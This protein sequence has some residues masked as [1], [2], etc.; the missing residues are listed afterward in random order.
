MPSQTKQLKRSNR[1]R[2]K[3]F[4]RY[5]ANHWIFIVIFLS[6]LA[7]FASLLAP[8]IKVA[9]DLWFAHATQGKSL[10]GWIIYR[11]T[12]W[13][14]RI[15]PESLTYIFS[16]CDYIWWKI[17]SLLVF[18]VVVIAG[19][20]YY[21]LLARKRSWSKDTLIF[22]AITFGIFIIGGSIMAN[23]VLWLS[24]SVNYFYGLPLLLIG[25]YPLFYILKK[26][27]PPKLL[28]AVI[29]II[30]TLLTAIFSEQFG[31]TIVIMQIVLL[32]LI[33]WDEKKLRPAK[34]K[35]RNF[36]FSKKYLAS[37]ITLIASTILYA[38]MMLSPGNHRRDIAEL[39][40][41]L[42]DMYTVSLGTRLESDIRW[43]CDSIVNHTGVILAIMCILLS[44]LLMRDR[45]TGAKLGG[46]ILAASGILLV[47]KNSNIPIVNS[48]F[49]F[50]AAWRFHGGL[51]SWLKIAIWIL[52][53][54]LIFISI[55][56]IFRR[57][58]KTQIILDSIFCLAMINAAVMFLSPTMYASGCRTL[59]LSAILLLILNVALLNFALNKISSNNTKHFA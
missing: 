33:F 20:Q 56:Y 27:R 1:N 42:P 47:F 31:M 24:G 46:A 10:F 28:T 58:R 17:C 48:I 36:V 57:Q 50:H 59:L 18:S 19:Y 14:S 9:D 6:G 41:W 49:N 22:A 21:K 16:K 35:L 29:G 26:Q 25:L 44:I 32:I 34:L 45:K 8:Q 11:F 53:L 12:N 51:V 5:L 4:G 40:T 39:H 15:V 3:T 43:F 2:A 7:L 13:S 37:K 54:L 38:I 55:L 52:I 23:G 30:C